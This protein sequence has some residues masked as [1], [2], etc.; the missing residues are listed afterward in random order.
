M[1]G[2]GLLLEGNGEV[3]A[4]GALSGAVKLAVEAKQKTVRGNY[5]LDGSLERPAI[6]K[7][8]N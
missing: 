7:L 1:T 6:H 3:S 4:K 8:A 5:K 2:K